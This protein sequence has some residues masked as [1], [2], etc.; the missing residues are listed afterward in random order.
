MFRFWGIFDMEFGGH[1]VNRKQSQSFLEESLGTG[2]VGTFFGFAS[3]SFEFYSSEDLK[4]IFKCK[5]NCLKKNSKVEQE[6]TGKQPHWS[7]FTFEAKKVLRWPFWLS[8]GRTET[9][10]RRLRLKHVVWSALILQE[11]LDLQ[12]NEYL[13]DWTQVSLCWLIKALKVQIDI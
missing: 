9:W 10:M 2:A 13:R 3:P 7:L 8:D 5:L 4:S 1:K 12:N 11:I 6:G